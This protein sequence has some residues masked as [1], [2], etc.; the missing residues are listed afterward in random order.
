MTTRTKKASEHGGASPG[1]LRERARTHARARKG[2]SGR[3]VT[4]RRPRS[5]KSIGGYGKIVNWSQLEVEADWNEE[6]RKYTLVR[7]DETSPSMSVDGCTQLVF[8]HDEDLSLPPVFLQQGRSHQLMGFHR[9][10]DELKKKEY[11]VTPDTRRFVQKLGDTVTSTLVE[12]AFATQ[13][14][15][16]DEYIYNFVKSVELRLDPYLQE[17]GLSTGDVYLLYKGGN[18]QYKYF[19]QLLL[20]RGVTD[21]DSYKKD[22]QDLMNQSKIS[23]ADFQVSFSNDE[24]YQRHC[25]DVK[26]IFVLAL[27]DFRKWLLEHPEVLSFT[28]LEAE[29]DDELDKGSFEADDSNMFYEERNLT[30]LPQNVRNL[31][32]SYMQKLQTANNF[33]NSSKMLETSELPNQLT[34][35]ERFRRKAIHDCQK[36]ANGLAEKRYSDGTKIDVIDLERQ[37]RRDFFIFE[38]RYKY[39]AQTN[40]SDEENYRR[41]QKIENRLI[42]N[43]RDLGG[44]SA[45]E[46][47]LPEYGDNMQGDDWKNA[48]TEEFTND[49]ELVDY[50]QRKTDMQKKEKERYEQERRKATEDDQ[51]KDKA[52]M[53]VVKPFIDELMNLDRNHGVDDDI[54]NQLAD[55]DSLIVKPSTLLT[56]PE[57]VY[58]ERLVKSPLYITYNDTLFIPKGNF[59]TVFDLIRLK[60][61]YKATVHIR[62]QRDEDG[63]D[64]DDATAPYKPKT[65]KNKLGKFFKKLVSPKKWQMRNRGGGTGVGGGYN[66]DILPPTQNVLGKDYYKASSPSTIRQMYFDR[67]KVNMDDNR[68][69]SQVKK[70]ENERLKSGVRNDKNNNAY[71]TRSMIAEG[72]GYC[73]FNA[74][75]ELIDVS[76]T[77]MGDSRTEKLM[78]RIGYTSDSKS[79]WTK[80]ITMYDPENKREPVDVPIPSLRYI[81]ENDLRSILFKEARV[82]WDDTKYAK[83]IARYWMGVTLLGLKDTAI[84]DDDE[85]IKDVTRFDD[86]DIDITINAFKRFRNGLK[87]VSRDL[88]RIAGSDA[89]RMLSDDN[90]VKENTGSL[91]DASHY[92]SAQNVFYNASQNNASQNARSH[93]HGLNT[94][95]LDDIYTDIDYAELNNLVRSDASNDAGTKLLVLMNKYFDR[96][97][98]E[99]PIVLLLRET[100]EDYDAV[101]LEVKSVLKNE[102]AGSGK[103]ILASYLEFVCTTMKYIDTLCRHL[104]R[105]RQQSVNDEFQSG[106]RKVAATATIRRNNKLSEPKRYSRPSTSTSASAGGKEAAAAVSSRTQYHKQQQKQ[107]GRGRCSP[108]SSN[109]SRR[110]TRKAEK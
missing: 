91:N 96:A 26:K 22:I 10:D 35:N 88:I 27:Y 105:V 20:A 45:Y 40:L 58:G 78:K 44:I 11:Y 34:S 62:E 80:D 59:L 72:P 41:K 15:S 81:T 21:N 54:L 73:Q 7:S 36:L 83:R 76:V 86:A 67:E 23:D 30:K 89:P 1:V 49:Q 108:R 51:C 24:V 37:N 48:F 19:R 90:Y 5:K 66:D 57:E 109:S 68:L 93:S 98:T 42:E 32:M 16:L 28:D 43:I 39:E 13:L 101:R 50:E 12:H 85:D 104:G 63:D 99:N 107:Q 65:S 46:Y 53:Q 69:R 74:P 33:A 55:V 94:T 31:Q 47:D 75:S 97:F 14:E 25:D 70:M 61:N 100:A 77:R 9:V 106:G 95:S 8:G 82:P 52:F 4:K 87:Y 3:G 38:N 110:T 64:I 18:V 84:R 17:H 56:T 60:L 103:K 71:D 29:M 79:H 102:G 2:S 92:N 6:S